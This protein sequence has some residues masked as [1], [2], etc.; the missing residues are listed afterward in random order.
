MEKPKYATI[1]SS[2]ALHDK[3]LSPME[4][5]LYSEIASKCE[6]DG[7]CYETSTYFAD[8]FGMCRE[9]VSRYINHLKECGYIETEILSGFVRHIRVKDLELVRLNII[10][11][12]YGFHE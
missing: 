11:Q 5:L 7:M 3:R 2:D 10:E 4:K 6:E 9:S 12:R 8:V 1:I